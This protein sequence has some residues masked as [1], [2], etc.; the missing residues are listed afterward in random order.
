MEEEAVRGPPGKL[1]CLWE[2][3]VFLG[4]KGCAGEIVV[5]DSKGVWKTRTVRRRP[6][7]DRWNKEGIEMAKG[8]PRRTSDAD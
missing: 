4:I 2:D 7:K 8:V 6:V 1:T 3:G 5:A